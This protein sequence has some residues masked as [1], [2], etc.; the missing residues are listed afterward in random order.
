M[1]RLDFTIIV[2]IGLIILGYIFPSYL[3]GLKDGQD[4][5]R[6]E[7]IEKGF[8]HYE[9]NSSGKTEFHWKNPMQSIENID[10]LV[11]ISL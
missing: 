2:W 6:K 1:K 9:V 3:I 11:R 5:C 10:K 4:K 8:A 7:A